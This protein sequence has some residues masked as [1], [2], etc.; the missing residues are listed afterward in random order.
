M[1]DLIIVDLY[2]TIVKPDSSLP[3][4]NG[5]DEFVQYYRQQGAKIVISTDGP[6]E[7]VIRTLYEF[8]LWDKVD[9]VYDERDLKRAEHGD[10][11]TGGSYIVKNLEKPCRKFSVDPSRAV[12]VGDN[13]YGRDQNAADH[14]GIRF[15]KVPQYRDEI[16]TWRERDSTEDYVDFDDSK[17]PFS[18][19]SL[20]GQL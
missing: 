7:T 16:P 14:Y 6:E 11:F 12:F 10:F 2:G 8:D 4:R 9:E 18:F 17:N 13:F 3:V 20:I 15:I 5:F 1:V 19:I